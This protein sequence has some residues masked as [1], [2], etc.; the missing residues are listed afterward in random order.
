MRKIEMKNI[1]GKKTFV[2][3]SEEVYTVLQIDWKN[4]KG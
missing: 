3:V 1:D 4:K 2:E